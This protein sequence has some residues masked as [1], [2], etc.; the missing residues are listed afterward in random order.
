MFT[1]NLTKIVVF[2]TIAM[3]CSCS[4]RDEKAIESEW[5]GKEITIPEQL[6]FEVLGERI[7]GGILSSEDISR[8]SL[9]EVEALAA[10]EVSANANLNT[11]YCTKLVNSDIEICEEKGEPSCVRCSRNI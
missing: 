2:W 11:G 6:S 3:T 4:N 5:I 10:C 8:I 7:D 1:K 9:N